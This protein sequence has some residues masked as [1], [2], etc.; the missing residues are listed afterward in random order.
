[1]RQGEEGGMSGGRRARLPMR[2]LDILA[3]ITGLTGGTLLIVNIQWFFTF[4]IGLLIVLA[5]GIGS[6]IPAYAFMRKKKYRDSIR[7]IREEQEKIRVDRIN[8][9][10]ESTGY[11]SA[12]PSSV[13]RKSIDSGDPRMIPIVRAYSQLEDLAKRNNIT[14]EVMREEYAPRFNGLAQLISFQSDVKENPSVYGIDRG[15]VD[16][17]IH[18][19]SN[20]LVRSIDNDVHEITDGQVL[21]ARATT[22]YI[23]NSDS[24]ISDPME[25]PSS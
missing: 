3:V 23:V 24:D 1:M 12:N 14:L 5:I 25:S 16:T 2:I 11:D 19:A 6:Y 18:D 15:A 8:H 13:L 21:S 7:T 4:L 20:A 22:D 9:G 17:M 10:S